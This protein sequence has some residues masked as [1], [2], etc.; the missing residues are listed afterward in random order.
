[1]F[2]VSNSFM[3]IVHSMLLVGD[4]SILLFMNLVSAHNGNANRVGAL[5]ITVIIRPIV[6]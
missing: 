6:Y 4:T 1:M 5:S 3:Y 2:T